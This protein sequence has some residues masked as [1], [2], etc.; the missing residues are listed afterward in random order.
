MQS[1][2]EIVRGMFMRF[3]PLVESLLSLSWGFL[4]TLCPLISLFMDKKNATLVVVFLA[5]FAFLSLKP[6]EQFNE[7][8]KILYQS[9]GILGQVKVFDHPSYEI[10]TDH[11]ERRALIVNNTLQTYVGLENNLEHN[12]WA[13][14]NMILLFLIRF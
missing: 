10:T 1:L 12:I 9:E 5:G 4:L 8:Y 6:S 2:L 11:R 7:E 3:L 13:W 14:A